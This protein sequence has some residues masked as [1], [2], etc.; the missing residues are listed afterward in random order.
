MIKII[1]INR[2]MSCSYHLS[3]L[4][5]TDR[6]LTNLISSELSAKRLVAT[7]ASWDALP[8]TTQFAVTAANHQFR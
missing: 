4:T 7:T 3:R 2:I 6:I 1:G 8:C 5:S